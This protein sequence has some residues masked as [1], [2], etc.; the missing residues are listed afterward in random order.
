MFKQAEFDGLS[1]RLFTRLHLI[2]FFAYIF[3]LTLKFGI[4]N[5]NLKLDLY[6]KN[7][8]QIH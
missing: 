8:L 1:C 2:Y 3:M 4:L 7:I 5:L 6:D